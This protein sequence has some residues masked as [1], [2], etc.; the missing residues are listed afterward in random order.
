M[1]SCDAPPCLTKLMLIPVRSLVKNFFHRKKSSVLFFFLLLVQKLPPSSNK[2][3]VTAASLTF[4]NLFSSNYYLQL[5][6]ASSWSS[7]VLTSCFSSYLAALQGQ[8]FFFFF[9]CHAK[10]NQCVSKYSCVKILSF[11]AA[12]LIIEAPRSSTACCF[13]WHRASCAVCRTG[14]RKKRTYQSHVDVNHKRRR[15]E[16]LQPLLSNCIFPFTCL[17]SGGLLMASWVKYKAS[18]GT[19]SWRAPWK[20]QTHIRLKMYLPKQKAQKLRSR[21]LSF[22]FYD[23]YRFL[24][25]DSLFLRFL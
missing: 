19:N 4:T 8:I 3:A 12:A 25:G 9:C 16:C 20:H 23:C 10:S 17:S 24:R 6:F 7:V 14:C 13:C 15:C 21:S 2:T 5:A 18:V 1:A 11:F 22:F